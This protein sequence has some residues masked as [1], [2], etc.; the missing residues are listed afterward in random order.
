[1]IDRFI[2]PGLNNVAPVGHNQVL[3]VDISGGPVAITLSGSDAEGDPLEFTFEEPNCAGALT[4]TAPNL[5]YDPSTCW[6]TDG[7]NFKVQSADGRSSGDLARIDIYLIEDSLTSPT[8]AAPGDAPGPTANAG[9]DIDIGIED[10]RD[11]FG[12]YHDPIGR[13]LVYNDW[14]CNCE[15][16]NCTLE[17]YPTYARL[18]ATAEG[19]FTCWYSVGAR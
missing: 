14:Y 7:F 4:G 10:P 17:N 6:E 12:E 15:P 13:P 2:E 9:G 19:T 3:A 11:L 16:N 8:A 18:T 5:S 1:M